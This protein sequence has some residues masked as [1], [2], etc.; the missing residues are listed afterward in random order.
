MR[1][2]KT[3]RLATRDYLHE[4]QM[5]GCFILALASVLGPMLVLF[6]L[7]F[8]IVGGMVNQLVEDPHNREIIPM[9]SG[10]FTADW[11]DEMRRRSDVEFIVPRTR[12]IAATIQLKSSSGS[13]IISMEV[14]P[15][16]AG[17]PLLSEIGVG[18]TGLDTVVLSKTAAMKLRAGP[19][20]T[21]DGSLQRRFNELN[22][23]SHLSLKV[24][25]IAPANAFPREAVFTSV[26]LAEALE[27]YRDGQAVP[28]LGWKGGI[29]TRAR[30]YPGFRLYADSIYDVAELHEG[31]VE[32]GI[33]VRT[34]TADIE[35]VQRM[36]R[37]LTMV[38]WAIAIIG[39][40]GFSLSLGAS[41]WAN[42]DRKSKQ[43]SVLRLVGFRTG[44]IMWF[45]MIQALY[46]AVLGWALA[47][48]IFRLAAWSINDML[49]SQMDIG[50]Q[51]CE[52]LPIHYL[53]ALGLTLSSSVLA[54]AL[55]GF[56][57]ARIEPSE[58]LREI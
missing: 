15:S 34:R 55:A 42:V 19:G 39:L 53:I 2:F 1:P 4:W 58:G 38:Y 41:L 45:P 26:K 29:G 8:G 32:L 54:S 16:D 48:A 25:A 10:R 27:D 20:D 56:R 11:I 6:G 37:N 40:V 5:S 50:E 18:P 24:A 14:I 44:D 28:A 33:E 7:K 23:R 49:A 51:V 35:L 31:L 46:T 13:R 9:G 57:S 17:D 36:D 22:E 21:L 3:F 47:A 43:L 12:S 30:T 52:L